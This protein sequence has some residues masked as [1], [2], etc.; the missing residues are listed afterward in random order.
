[1]LGNTVRGIAVLL[2]ASS[3]FISAVSDDPAR[4]KSLDTALYS[5]AGSPGGA[6]LLIIVGAG[7]VSFG[8][9]SVFESRF[10]RV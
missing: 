5:L 1:M 7:F 10:R 4:A 9:H 6:A 8:F 2:V 3:L